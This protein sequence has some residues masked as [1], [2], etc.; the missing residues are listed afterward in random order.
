M[1][2]TYH[3]RVN[4]YDAM[5]VQQLWEDCIMLDIPFQDP[6]MSPSQVHYDRVIRQLQQDVRNAQKAVLRPY[7]FDREAFRCQPY[8]E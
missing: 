1:K 4:G 5:L 3:D 2:P 8:S 6:A 7:S